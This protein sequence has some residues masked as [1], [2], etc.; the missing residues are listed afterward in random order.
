[1]NNLLGLL[2]SVLL[3]SCLR[4]SASTA[5]D[6]RYENYGFLQPDDLEA[7]ND[8]CECK[9]GLCSCCIEMQ[10]FKACSKME[11]VENRDDE[12]KL[13]Y[14]LKLTILVNG[15]EMVS[16]SFPVS[17]IPPLCYEAEGLEICTK[18]AIRREMSDFKACASLQLKVNK[19]LIH[20]QE[21]YCIDIPS[22]KSANYENISN[23][24][25]GSVITRRRIGRL[26]PPN[27]RRSGY[28]NFADTGSGASQQA[29]VSES[30]EID[31]PHIID[32]IHDYSL[33]RID[34]NDDNDQWADW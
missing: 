23:M 6:N 30:F 20:E 27:D 34:R 17:D 4:I 33:K 25:Y 19:K 22:S 29:R 9:N 2:G 12:E 21:M 3:I 15:Q 8:L 18:I 16:Q 31:P 26:T 5:V 14:K 11:I 13:S 32:P 1:M 24:P 28:D 7:L 10:K